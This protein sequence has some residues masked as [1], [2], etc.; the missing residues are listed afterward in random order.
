MIKTKILILFTILIFI[1]LSNKLFA[2]ESAGIIKYRQNI[3]KATA[4][5]MGAIVGILKNNL[6]IKEHIIEHAHSLKKIS[7]M[8]FN[9]FP[10]GSGSGR[11][12]AKKAIW[13]NWSKFERVTQDFVDESTKLLEIAKNGNTSAIAKQVRKTGKT[14]SGCHK[15]FRKRD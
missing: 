13:D 2:S 14:C 4:G 3:M 15:N 5:H 7:E 10:K 12:K 6:P 1:V 9:I 11:T 8:T